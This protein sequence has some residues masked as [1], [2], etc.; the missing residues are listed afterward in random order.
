MV[1]TAVPFAF[2]AE[3]DTEAASYDLSYAF[4]LATEKTYAGGA[5]GLI[6]DYDGGLTPKLDQG[7]LHGTNDAA[8]ITANIFAL[9]YFYGSAGSYYA[10]KNLNR[11]SVNHF[12]PEDTNNANQ[13][14][15][16]TSLAFT[17][18]ANINDAAGDYVRDD[19]YGTLAYNFEAGC[20]DELAMTSRTGTDSQTIPVIRFRV[21]R[22]GYINPVIKLSTLNDAGLLYR[23]RK[24]HFDDP[25]GILNNTGWATNNAVLHE[26]AEY[27]EIYPMTGEETFTRS[28][29]VTI[30]EVV[31]PLG[32]WAKA[33]AGEMTVRDQALIWVDAGDEIW[34][35]IG[36]TGTS[37]VTFAIDTLRF[38]YVDDSFTLNTNVAYKASN[39]ILNVAAIL[40]NAGISVENA[41]YA[42]AESSQAL[43]TAAGTDGVFTI[44][45]TVENGAVVTVNVTLPGLELIV[46]ATLSVPTLTYDLGDAYAITNSFTGDPV[47]DYAS[48]LT[49]V[50]P[51][52]KTNMWYLAYGW[53]AD[54]YSTSYA[55][56][57]LT[58]P[59]YNTYAPGDLQNPFRLD[60]TGAE[61]L[62]FSSSAPSSQTIDGTAYKT[63]RGVQYG[64]IAY[65]F[66]AGKLNDT[67]AL[68][69][70][71]TA[72]LAWAMPQIVFTAPKAGL[73][74]P[75]LVI[76]TNH[77]EN[78]DLAYRVFKNSVENNIY[79]KDG[80]ASATANIST[81]ITSE[82]MKTGWAVS[83][84]GK[85]T[86]RDD[87]YVYVEEGDKIYI[88]FDT[89]AS[90]YLQMNYTIDSI[91]MVYTEVI[92]ETVN[93][94]Y[95]GT[96]ATTVDATAIAAAYGLTEGA[97]YTLT[98]AADALAPTG[99][100]GIYAVTANTMTPAKITVAAGDFELVIQ[101]NSSAAVSE[102][103]F[104]DSTAAGL[105][106]IGAAN[107]NKNFLALAYDANGNILA[108][109]SNS[110]SKTVDS[111]GN[112][113]FFLDT[114][115]APAYIRLFMWEDLDN[116]RPYAAPLIVRPTTQ[117]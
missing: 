1:F 108:T 36:K 109:N 95:N 6:S 27:S 94:T 46:N 54:G 111:D 86:T 35:Q 77:D 49:P 55:H 22:S 110:N 2:A 25:T 61:S 116:I 18:A 68:H 37:N 96:E 51:M 81:N 90:D 5:D 106:S 33:P 107:A 87:A 31:A 32:G 15:G 114:T 48:N 101:V 12:A 113:I 80:E 3:L 78:N 105:V 70:G 24:L 89:V 16:M 92:N 62:S 75:R 7:I 74:N 73:I 63:N 21:P 10:N 58:R 39:P 53:S 91:Q 38:D 102:Y 98:D 84:Y 45:D 79:P 71:G 97:T 19:T 44:A 64:N 112:V 50:T 41:T 47:A 100:A 9:G 40:Q 82:A 66:G 30:S 17:Y 8:G 23:V 4:E 88:L 34:L 43:L 117:Q 83:E 65:N 28:S 29:A 20:Y 11:P 115:T 59:V 13:A 76:G 14:T 57:N 72:Y 42:V 26:A 93:V 85:L 104:D 56:A 52:A 99:T 60:G 67:S 103:G 69:V